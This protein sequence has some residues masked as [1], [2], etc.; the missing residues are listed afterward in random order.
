MV[1][2]GIPNPSVSA[3]T[4]ALTREELSK[5]CRR[6]TRGTQA[7]SHLLQ[8]LLLSLSIATNN[9]GVLLLRK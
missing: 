7:T 6:I 9:L 5:H 3:V 8:N 1:R 4:K 2:D